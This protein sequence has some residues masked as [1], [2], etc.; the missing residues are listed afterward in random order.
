MKVASSGG[1]HA[2]ED[3]DLRPL[4]GLGQHVAAQP[5]G[6]EGQRVELGQ[7]RSCGT[8]RRRLPIPC[9]AARAGRRRSGRRWGRWARRSPSPPVFGAGPMK[10]GGAFGSAISCCQ[11]PAT[12]PERREQDQQQE[13]ADDGERHQADA[14]AAKAQPRGRPDAGVALRGARVAGR[15]ALISVAKCWPDRRPFRWTVLRFGPVRRRRARRPA[16]D[17]RLRVARRRPAAAL[18][19][20]TAQNDAR[21]SR[22]LRPRGI[23]CRHACQHA[24]GATGPQGG[25]VTRV[26]RSERRRRR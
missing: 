18:L 22:A 2:D 4:D 19:L 13:R 10:P 7:S 1:E 17:A 14:V 24:R 3:R 5:V 23:V 15:T 12:R 6:A 25:G 9:S 16:G 26:R 8:W 20:Y 21:P 11:L